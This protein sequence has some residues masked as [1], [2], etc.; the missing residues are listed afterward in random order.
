MS[1][2]LIHTQ[3]SGT[4]AHS[5]PSHFHTPEGYDA[6]ILDAVGVLFGMTLL[7]NAEASIALRNS[8]PFPSQI[9]TTVLSGFKGT[10]MNPDISPHR[11]GDW[12]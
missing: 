10:Q 5:D 8:P 9:S 12:D 4:Q 7:T 2:P 3:I 6:V 11:S 1:R